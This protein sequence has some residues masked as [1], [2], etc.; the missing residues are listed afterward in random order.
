MITNLSSDAEGA[1]MLSLSDLE[2]AQ[3]G[4]I[5]LIAVAIAAAA[6]GATVGKNCGERD[7]RADDKK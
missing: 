7:N 1:A 2:E 3:G 6:L 5:P 4:I